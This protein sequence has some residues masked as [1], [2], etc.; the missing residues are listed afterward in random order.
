MS[1]Y[2]WLIAITLFASAHIGYAQKRKREPKVPPASPAFPR[3]DKPQKSVT[4]RQLREDLPRGLVAVV[5]ARAFSGRHMQGCGM[6]MRLREQPR[7]A[8]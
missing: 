3:R 1:R 6:W 7:W 2:H 8:R 4:R 5:I